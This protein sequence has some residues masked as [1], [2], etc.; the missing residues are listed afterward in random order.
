MK[1][2]TVCEILAISIVLTILAGGVAVGA[3]TVNNVS[4]SVAPVNKSEKQSGTAT[5]EYW[6][7]IVGA[8]SHYAYQNAEDMYN[9]LTRRSDNWDTDHIRFLV[10]ES[11]TKSNIRD[12]IQWMANKASA[13]DTCLFYFSGHGNS[14]IDYNGDEVD[15]LDESLSTF[16]DSII[17]DELEEWIDEIKTEKVVAIL[18]A[19]HSGGVLTP[20]L[21]ISE[22][23][24]AYD[25]D[26]FASDLEKAD[27]LVLASNRMDEEGYDVHELKNSVFT[28]FIVQG[29][30]GAADKDNNGEISVREVCDYSFPKIVDYS[31]DTQ[32]PLLWPDDN[33]A[34][35]FT[36]I[37][38]K[39]S[40]PKRIRVPDEY[41]IIQEAVEA[42][43]PG[44][45]IEVSP[46]SYTETII[47]N[48]PLT[49]N[50]PHGGAIIQAANTSLS[51]IFITIGNTTLSGLTCQ[52][53]ANGIFLYKS[54]NSTIKNNAATS[55]G[56]AGICF[57]S[58]S[59][60][61]FTNNIVN[62]N[63]MFGILMD[64][65]SDIMF[66]NNIVNS[67]GMFGIYPFFSNSNRFTNNTAN[68]NG[69]VGIYPLFS[70]NNMFTNNTANSNSIGI[71]LGYSNNTILTNN[72]AKSNSMIGIYQLFSS[73]NMFTN[74]TA[75][76]NSMFGIILHSSSNNILTNNIANSNS[77]FGIYLNSSS[78][79]TLTS[80]TVN[81]NT[82]VGICLLN[83]SSSNNLYLNN[84]INN[85]ENVYSDNSTNIWNSPGKMKYTYNKTT[86][87]NYLGNYWSD[88]T[89][90]D[91]DGDGVGDAL[92][93]INGDLDRYPLMVY[94][95]KYSAL[96]EFPIHNLDTEK[97][98]SSIQAAIDDPETLDGHTIT[99]D[100][101][102][103]TEN[104]EVTKSL[105]VRSTSGNPA[106]TIV[107]AANLRDPVFN[108]T[109]DYVNI[110]GFTVT[111]AW[112]AG[113]YL[114]HADHCNI[115]KNNCSNDIEGIYLKNSNNNSI[116][117]NNCSDNWNSDI[118]LWFSRNNKLTGNVMVE[119]GIV[120]G[121]D[122]LGEFTHVIEESN[123]VNGKPVYY[124]KEV[125]GGRIPDGAGQVILVNCTNVFVEN[126]N[127]NNAS[128]G[129]QIAFSSHITIRSNNCSN[130][131]AAGI[132]L[133]ESKNNCILNNNCSSNN[134]IGIALYSSSDNKI[135][136]N[137]AN[138][139]SMHGIYLKLSNNNILIDNNASYNFDTG[140][141]LKYGS[142]NNT[143]RGN[144]ANSNKQHH[145]ISL[146]NLSTN[147]TI[148][149][150]N[151]SSNKDTGIVLF[152][153]HDNEITNNTANLNNML[154]IDLEDSSNNNTIKGNT[155]NLNKHHGIQLSS[156]NNNIII[157]NNASYNSGTGIV[158]SGSTNNTI[159]G[160][161][162]NA[163]KQY[164]GIY[165]ELS[166]NNII[167]YNNASN[168][169]QV[170]IALANSNN[171]IIIDNTANLNN[172]YG[173]DLWRSS[174]NNTI[175]GNTLNL[176]ILDGIQLISSNNNI[177]IYNN[178]SYN[179]D[180]G[181]TLF[182][183]NN[184]SISNNN[185]SHNSYFGIFI[186]YS[187]NS[188][189]V[190]NTCSNN[191]YGISLNSSSGN[192][193]TGN[194]VSNNTYDGLSLYS[195]NSNNTITGNIVSNTYDG[196]SLVSSSN[197]K[198]YLNSFINNNY[199]VYSEE[200]TNIWNS[201]EK[202]T[203]YNG[204]Y[205]NYLG[206]YWSDYTGSDMDKDGIGDTPH[207]IDGD[208]DNYPLMVPLENYFA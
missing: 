75:N 110:S 42:A 40:I 144:I 150:N 45:T 153:S 168:N 33:T 53:G 152:S 62:S 192:T 94:P 196:I 166:Y 52:N 21:Q 23:V 7:V 58:S 5:A 169:F 159:R 4:D 113:I 203:Y 57:N 128:I 43:M 102:T 189:I 148:I 206:N 139:N 174:N 172:M 199:N 16:D 98:F 149:D 188:S 201:P 146:S 111:G 154:G 195:S 22:A 69:M 180:T 77:M 1:N 50:A 60:I 126:Q 47:I 147:N 135:T 14:P 18:D 202:I 117:N 35:N 36:L 156:S 197:N 190:N 183:S 184:S 19:C 61:M 9:V 178:A 3:G 198:I 112:G 208:K 56:M 125:E 39:A 133:K 79:N 38:L 91:T 64:S 12:A 116:S 20:F 86:Y 105:T 32:H 68:S 185:C 11:A 48:K 15:G 31:E 78:D 141:T 66:T 25:L 132:D 118:S 55:N 87:T 142:N 207:S 27:C 127:L 80:N 34:N 134:H 37:K 109:A 76:S 137:T 204:T 13:G 205:T 28:Y 165:L 72:T 129:V 122:S 176:N 101:G 97:N 114:Y 143:L 186:S 81:S 88:Y 41:R 187:N 200:S 71:F 157:D 160:N 84:F 24:E 130:N 158:L 96:L 100:S 46:G 145:G 73:N 89:G 63:G 51:C 44:D 194:I 161:I 155:M 2:K 90:S 193:I 29:L 99:V 175:K 93:S 74:N 163:N 171:N 179:F 115:S 162:A 6:A 85:I 181:I 151:C 10:N 124:W 104:V 59:D 65:S 182:D 120:I 49:I 17:D 83:C 30:W 106:D 167:I 177:I 164:N 136:N 26:G 170:G 8:T 82:I 191:D 123:T 173:I 107:N 54:N 108:V 131:W 103:Y 92:Y 70:S 119:N 67:N 140:I 121:G 95:E 138:L